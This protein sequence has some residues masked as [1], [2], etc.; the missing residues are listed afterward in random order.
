MPL[1]NVIQE[2]IQY[3][4]QRKIFNQPV[5]HNQTVHFRLAEL[6]TEVELL[7]SLLYRAVAHY[8]KGNDVTKL[9]SMAKLKAGRLAREVCDSC[10][11]FWGGMGFT[12][13]V[14]VSRLY[15]FLFNN[16]V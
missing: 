9:A 8:V 13:E 4:H 14:L 16:E 11:Q 15:S 3:T 12:N 5:L 1:Q 10:L 7:R 2:T 6:E